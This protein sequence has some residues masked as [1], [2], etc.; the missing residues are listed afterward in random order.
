MEA[1]PRQK[2]RLSFHNVL[3]NGR[4]I[5]RIMLQP[6]VPEGEPWFWLT[7]CRA[8]AR[9]FTLTWPHNRV[10]SIFNEPTPNAVRG[11][12]SSGPLRGTAVEEKRQLNLSN[13][14]SRTMFPVWKG[15]LWNQ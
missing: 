8:R 3:D 15:A 11:P 4:E 6:Q 12:T 14:N 1:T 9:R 13:S 5:G 2:L 10:Q 7:L